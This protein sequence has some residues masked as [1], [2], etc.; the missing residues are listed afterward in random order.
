M[1]IKLQVSG[2]VTGVRRPPV[3]VD[4]AEAGDGAELEQLAGEVARQAAPGGPPGPDRFQY[5]LEVDGEPVRLHEAA[6]TPEA[7]ELIRRLRR[8][9]A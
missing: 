1:R 2:G 4:T 9:P 7:E 6:L 3:E 8:R 5:D